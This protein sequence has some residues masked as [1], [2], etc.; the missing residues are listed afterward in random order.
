MI[1]EQ[2]NSGLNQKGQNPR[3]IVLEMLLKIFEEGQFCHTV[4]NRTLL[5]CMGLGKQERAFIARLCRGTVERCITLD[6]EIEKYS[7]LKVAKMKPLIRN[8]L[9]MSAYQFGYMSIPS[10]AICNEAVKIVKK[11]KM[12]GLTGFVNGVLRKMSEQRETFG[13]QI[14]GLSEKQRLSLEYSMP[15]WLVAEWLERYQTQQTIQMLQWFLKESPLTVRMN[16]RKG[17]VQKVIQEL[18]KAK[19]TALPGNLWP[20]AYILQGIDTLAGLQAFQEGLFQVQDESSMC[21]A[22]LAGIQAGDQILD[23]CAAPG[24]KALHAAELLLCAEEN[25]TVNGK[26]IARDISETKAELIRENLTR[27]GYHN[28]TIEVKDASVYA[29]EDEFTA[30]IVLADLP[31]SGLG[32]LGRKPDIRY[33]VTKESQ[34]RLATLQREILAVVSRYVKPGGVLIYSTCTIGEEENEQN[35]SYLSSELG[36]KPESLDT[37]LPDILHTETTKR[38]YLQLLPG[39]YG[40]DGFFFAKFRKK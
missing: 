21:V 33:K 10:S 17:S 14:E 37:Y 2:K 32:I 34:K 4:I 31:C 26:V 20:E 22:R 6:Y 19:V 24:G 8:L 27:S 1:K 15:E 13:G 36:L 30:D 3:E 16:E 12:F 39:A 25:S 23:V 9:R 18:A 28:V 40:T 29:P 7:S 5:A 11:R 38:G 35:Y